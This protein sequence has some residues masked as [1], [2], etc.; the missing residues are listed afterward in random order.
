[1]KVIGN[2][3]NE[4]LSKNTSGKDQ[5]EAEG[6]GDDNMEIVEIPVANRA[7]AKSAGNGTAVNVRVFNKVATIK[8]TCFRESS[9]S[10]TRTFRYVKFTCRT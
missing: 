10:R 7:D 1:M 2:I 8:R 9:S 3:N 5:K 6:Q 4:S